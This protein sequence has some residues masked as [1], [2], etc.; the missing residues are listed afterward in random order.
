MLKLKKIK[1]LVITLSAATLLGTTLLPVAQIYAS[2]SPSTTEISTDEGKND[3]V[4]TPQEI[5]N[6]Q[7]EAQ[8]THET[9]S[10]IQQ[11][12]PI[13]VTTKVLKSALKKY[14]KTIAKKVGGKA[15]AWLDKNLSK[16]IQRLDY[17]GGQARGGLKAVLKGLGLSNSTAEL[18][19]DIIVTV[20]EWLI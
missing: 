1:N 6:I 2:E 19:A 15:G 9:N 14:G 3:N 18:W 13:S 7:F 17:V 12:G 10:S 20:V 11:R 16:V 8:N 5:K 4:L